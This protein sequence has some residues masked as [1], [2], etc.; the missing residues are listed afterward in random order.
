MLAV[1]EKT[2]ALLYRGQKNV[3]NNNAVN[4]PGNRKYEPSDFKRR[5]SALSKRSAVRVCLIEIALQVHAIPAVFVV[6]TSLHSV[7]FA[8]A[9]FGHN[10]QN[11]NL[12]SIEN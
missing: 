1:H 12:G 7:I 3:A 5:E 8:G 9:G 2:L 10:T 4:K 11:W 6:P